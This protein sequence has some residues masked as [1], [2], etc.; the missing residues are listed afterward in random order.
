MAELINVALP[1]FASQK[2]SS[3]PL[4]DQRGRVAPSAETWTLAPG[5]GNGSTYTCERPLSFEVTPTH[6]PSGDTW[7]SRSAAALA[8]SGWA[9]GAPAA[10]NGSTM[11]RDGPLALD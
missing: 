3:R 9:T 8:R 2:S 6:L 4:A 7:A 5:P 11:I 1:E 10:S